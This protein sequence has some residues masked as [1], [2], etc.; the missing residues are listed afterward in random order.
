MHGLIQIN[1][2]LDLPEPECSPA[3]EVE[4]AQSQQRIHGDGDEP[5]DENSE[6]SNLN[7]QLVAEAKAVFGD[8]LLKSGKT[9]TAIR[10]LIRT[11]RSSAP[12]KVIECLFMAGKKK[13]CRS[14]ARMNVMPTSVGRRINST[15]KGRA[16]LK[17]GRPRKGTDYVNKRPHS[18]LKAVNKNT[19]NAK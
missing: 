8:V 5:M 9:E 16:P 17:H 3:V 14:G 13:I 12:N 2:L 19:A 11:L 4:P 15:Y 7:P 18:L 10:Q 1:W 6:I